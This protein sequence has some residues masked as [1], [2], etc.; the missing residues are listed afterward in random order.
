MEKVIFVDD[1]TEQRSY[2]WIKEQHTPDGYRDFVATE[3]TLKMLDAGNRLLPVVP[4][5]RDFEIKGVLDADWHVNDNQFSLYIHFDY[6]VHKRKG[7]VIG[8]RSDGKALIVSL[9]NDHRLITVEKLNHLILERI[10]SKKFVVFQVTMHNSE[11]ALFLDA[12]KC[13]SYNVNRTPG[14]LALERGVFFGE[15]RMKSFEITSPDELEERPIWDKLV[16]PFA[17]INGMDNPIIW[18]VSA[19]QIGKIVQLDIELSGGVKERPLP[20]W[21]SESAGDS[22]IEELQKPYLRLESPPQSI[23]LVLTSKTI[24]LCHRPCKLFYPLKGGEPEWPLRRRFFLNV[25]DY[26]NALLFC[27]YESYRNTSVN[28]HL[29]GMASETVYDCKSK[30]IVYYGEALE[31][32]TVAVRLKSPADKQICRAIPRSTHE[33]EKALY[34]AQENH[35]FHESEEC[36]FYFEVFS[37]LGSAK[38]ELRLEYCLQNA[39]FQSMKS[40]NEVIWLDRSDTVAADIEKIYSSKISFGNLKPGVYH[41]AFRLFQ[42]VIPL[43]E[44]TRAF[45]IYSSEQSGPE[46]SKLPKL[47]C[48]VTENMGQDTDYFDPYKQ[49]CVDAAHYLSIAVSVM[50]HCVRTKR[51]WELYRLYKREWFLWL[52]NRTTRDC[53]LE[54]NHDLVK[55]C[56]YLLSP[57]TLQQVSLYRLSSRVFYR[58]IILE[59][60]LEFVQEKRLDPAGVQVAI[61]NNAVL[62][63]DS[64]NQLVVKHFYSWIKFFCAGFIEMMKVKKN[65]IRQ[66]NSKAKFSDYG[67][68]AIYAASYKTAHATTYVGGLWHSKVIMD[69]FDGF[70]VFEDYPHAARYNINRGPFLM[71]SMKR[72]FPKWIFYPEM[73]GISGNLCL[74]AA[75][76]CAWPSIGDRPESELTLEFTVKRVMEYVYATVWHDGKEFKYWQDY[77]FQTRAWERKRYEALLKAWG[78]I[79]RVK[80][81]EP[82]KANAFICNET[83]CINHE[84]FYDEYAGEDWGD[85][86]NTAEEAVAYAYEMSRNAGQN[87][88]FIAD[89]DSLESLA[90]DTIDTLV[91]PPL[92]KVAPKDLDN[93]RRLHKQG[94]ALLGFENV[95]GLE[96]LFGVK[97]G[98]IKQLNN[99]EVNHNLPENPLL[100]LSG[101]REYTEHRACKGKYLGAGA[102]ILLEGEIPVLFSHKTPWGKTALFNIPPSAVRRQ[103][104]SHRICYGRD[105]ISPLINKSVQLVLRHLSRPTVETDAG[106]LI[107][108]KDIMGDIHII[109][110]EDAHPCPATTIKPLLTVNIPGLQ[111]RKICCDRE[112][113]IVSTTQDAVKLRLKLARDEIAILTIK[114]AGHEI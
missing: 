52:T 112:F 50:P 23:G 9:G 44:Q 76:S 109:V 16:I 87:A 35:Y 53:R 47:F 32:G 54:L 85:I 26:H 89:F 79:D 101:L 33:Y 21:I 4:I 43:K 81:L 27:G 42:G 14:L 66:I 99:I 107:A 77:G 40:V 64:F 45:E 15:L 25:F 106:K 34:F 11:L 103:D 38:G 12:E 56:D 110:E 98:K 17:P 75:I 18:T 8:F 111:T 93:I 104:Q 63:I 39:F 20:D 31:S 57:N 105:N 1:F 71:A 96:D 94:V 74:D 78:F 69:I 61:S 113:A 3:G 83:C 58:G 67:P 7:T 65:N 86:F 114:S 60:L 36:T 92:T 84:V 95:N 70:F 13:F 10:I 30:K 48:M 68:V 88:G 90:A 29:A 102:D 80:A 19:K 22:Y 37:R 72:V 55:N 6:D 73:Y 91:L 51:L 49:E 5:L 97:T 59:V 41:L 28:K 100:E 2:C 24:L 62:D 108:F 82:L 46:A